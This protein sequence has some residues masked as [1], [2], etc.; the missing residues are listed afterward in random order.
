M[1]IEVHDNGPGILAMDM[2][3]IFDP[4]YTTKDVGKGSGLGLAVTR[5]II[6][7]HGGAIT[8]ESG[9]GRGVTFFISLPLRVEAEQKQGV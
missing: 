5:E 1:L 6:T 9:P 3:K 2:E 4:F 7:K 8:V